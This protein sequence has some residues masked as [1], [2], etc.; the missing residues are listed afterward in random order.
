MVK[1]SKRR[2]KTFRLGDITLRLFP[3]QAPKTVTNFL[4]LASEG[5][6]SNTAFHK[7]VDGKMIQGGHIGEDTSNPN[8]VSSYGVPFEDEFCDKLFNIRGSVAMV[9]SSADTN[10]SQFIINQAGVS[11]F[12]DNGGWV[13]L[14]SKWKETKNSC[15][16]I[17]TLTF[18]LPILS[19]TQ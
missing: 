14:D 15:Q 18:F 12:K 1:T 6:Y 2:T 4:T 13:E 3:D 11:S 16:I 5:K 19:K 17:R 10:G 9:S 8:G 7:V